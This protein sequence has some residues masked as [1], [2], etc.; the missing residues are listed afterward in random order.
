MKVVPLPAFES[1]DRVS[2]NADMKFI[3]AFTAVAKQ[4]NNH[5]IIIMELKLI[6]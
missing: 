2:I 3:T 5:N 6:T 1:Q 4:N